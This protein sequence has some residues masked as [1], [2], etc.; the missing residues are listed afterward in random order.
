MR[1]ELRMVNTYSCEGGG[2]LLLTLAWVQVL[3][4][5]LLLDTERFPSV[6]PHRPTL[7]SP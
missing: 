5:F 1:E 6:S 3:A 7:P 4:R 2:E